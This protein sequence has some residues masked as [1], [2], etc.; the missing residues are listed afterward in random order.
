MQTKNKHKVKIALDI[1]MAIV[2]AILFNKTALG[3]M[4]F[5]EIAG[6]AIGAFIII[7]MIQN[8]AWLKGVTKK[9]FNPK[10]PVRTRVAYIV[11]ALLLIA[12]AVIIVTGILMSKVLFASVINV[13]L[14]VESLHKAVSYIALALIGTHI[15]LSWNRVVAIVKKLLNIPKKR[16]LGAIATAC[17][18]IVFSLGSYNIVST[19]YFNK[20]ASIASGYSERGNSGYSFGEGEVSSSADLAAFIDGNGG[21][22]MNGESRHENSNALSTIYQNLSI[23]AAFAVF[24]FYIDKLMHRKKKKTGKVAAE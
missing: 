19:G 21:R 13:H 6:L 1:L 12:V 9:L 17:A 23:V 11:D 4:T 2:F 14:N 22:K 3:G 5:H 18:I 7:H 15:G 24:T 20:V 10:L 16:A 8:R